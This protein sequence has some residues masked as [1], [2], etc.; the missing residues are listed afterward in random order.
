MSDITDPTNRSHEEIQTGAKNEFVRDLL[1]RAAQHRHQ[2]ENDDYNNEYLHKERLCLEQAANRL[3][4]DLSMD[5]SACFVVHTRLAC[6]YHQLTAVPPSDITASTATD[7]W[8]QRANDAAVTAINM[9][10]K[11]FN[12]RTQYRKDSPYQRLMKFLNALLL[13]GQT[14]SQEQQ[15]V[16][17]KASITLKIVYAK[18]SLKDVRNGLR[19]CGDLEKTPYELVPYRDIADVAY[20]EVV[21]EEREEESNDGDMVTVHKTTSKER[22]KQLRM[23]KFGQQADD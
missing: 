19:M 1:S 4:N 2:V 18:R 10:I 9:Y 3:F 11:V 6:L 15:S 13:R 12:S 22:R 21:C 7:I 16:T 23:L 14:I 5:I 8:E 17:T 20:D